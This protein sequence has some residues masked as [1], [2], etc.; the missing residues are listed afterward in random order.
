ML[1]HILENFYAVAIIASYAS[2]IMR[3]N[4]RSQKFWQMSAQKFLCWPRTRVLEQGSE[5]LDDH[6]PSHSRSRGSG[7]LT[8]KLVVGFTLTRTD[9]RDLNLISPF[10][11]TGIRPSFENFPSLFIKSVEMMVPLFW[12][13]SQFC[14]VI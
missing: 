6:Q 5:T 9:S 2:C 13:H 8:L 12:I 4:L 7:P 11:P 1:S 3:V 14:F 10:F